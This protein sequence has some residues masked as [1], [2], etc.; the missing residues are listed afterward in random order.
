MS[1]PSGTNHNF[2]YLANTQLS[3][4]TISTI[5]NIPPTAWNNLQLMNQSVGTTS[6]PTFY[7]LS[8][9]HTIKLAN[10]LSTAPALSFTSDPN[11][12][13]YSTGVSGEIGVSSDNTLKLLVSN[14]EVQIQNSNFVCLGAN[15][16][17]SD[18]MADKCTIQYSSGDVYTAGN[19]GIKQAV[20][21]EALEVT[22]NIKTTG[23]V[24]LYDSTF[25]N[26]I[27]TT[28]LT[29]N[30]TL[31]LPNADLALTQYSGP[32]QSV[33]SS[34]SPQFAK[35]GVGTPAGTNTLEVTGNAKVTGNY[36]AFN[37]SMLRSSVSNATL[38]VRAVS[39]WTTSS[40]SGMDN[41][42]LGLCWSPQLGLFV[43][44]SY[45]GTGTRVMTSS[46]GVTWAL[47]KSAADNDWWSVCWSP[48]LSLFVAVGASGTGNRV[49]TSPDG[50]SWTTRTSAADNQWTNVCWSPELG[51]FCA[52]AK[53][54]TNR[55]MTSSNGI[56]WATQTPS[57]DNEWYSVCWS[58]ELG[59]FC[60][61]SNNGTSRVMTSSNGINW[62][63]RTAAAS[64][65]WNSVCWS[66]ELS[67][68]VAVGASGTGNRV[69]TS[70][71]GIDWTSRTSAAD[72]YWVSVCWSPGLGTFCAI[73]NTGTGNRIMT[74]PDGITWTS[75]TSAADNSWN[76][77][78]W[79]PELGIFAAIGQSG[80]ANR[81]M[82]SKKTYNSTYSTSNVPG[83]V[84]C[85]GSFVRQPQTGGTLIDFR[86]ND[87]YGIYA[88]SANISS[89]G[90]TLNF[91]ADDYN[92]NSATTRDVL[93]LRPE[94][95]VVVHSLTSNGAVYS[96]S[97]Y[98]TN[99]NPSD[100]KWK[101]NIKSIDKALDQIKRLRPVSYKWKEG[102][103][104]DHDDVGF[105]A[106]E[107]EQVFP[108]MVGE[109][110]VE[111]AD[112][113]HTG[114]LKPDVGKGTKPDKLIPYLV[115]AI[116]ELAEMI[117]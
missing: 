107:L 116:Q 34:A 102:K 53:S 41:S 36:I 31:T 97:G 11:S 14:T 42:W 89:R 47:G 80:T 91:K 38:G 72:I 48:E 33:S 101:Q 44:V 112:P 56:D 24:K 66:P 100:A 106:G 103:Q 58:A 8:I 35:I 62:D 67:L 57:A 64:N 20:G 46:D 98:L 94:G 27:A 26:S 2:G 117:R 54:G 9:A 76:R 115:K 85:N 50:F 10:G 61:V 92:N 63:A 15:V 21:T 59:I 93:T 68:F 105:I 19:V 75:R 71:N 23:L 4:Q 110:F 81:V 74:S 60:A 16:R 43:S 7:G 1:Y 99:T 82:I 77:I 108:E 86:S 13:I 69:M 52:V 78:C 40:T 18:G 25:T 30:R 45:S 3:A 95:T 5:N 109:S 17:V 29:G 84:K 28:T 55:V 104:K 12:G 83:N 70:P 51:L 49:M 32:N 79:S 65:S 37:N 90:Y 111:V 39:T 73:S 88:A 113:E 114:E 6:S 87:T 22:G 96:N